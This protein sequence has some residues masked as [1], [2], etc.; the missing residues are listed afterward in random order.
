[1]TNRPIFWAARR[2]QLAW[3]CVKK[4]FIKI[5]SFIFGI[6]NFKYAYLTT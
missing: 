5:A 3:W 6:S 2:N 4:A 1:M